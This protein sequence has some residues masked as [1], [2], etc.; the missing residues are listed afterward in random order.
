M[1]NLLNLWWLILRTF[2]KPNVEEHFVLSECIYVCCFYFIL[3]NI[4]YC[5]FGIEVWFISSKN[6]KLIPEAEDYKY[7]SPQL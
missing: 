4:M 1:L 3:F 2:L 7:W 6:H 5:V